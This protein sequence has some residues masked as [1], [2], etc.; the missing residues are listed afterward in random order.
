MIMTLMMTLS[1]HLVYTPGKSG[2]A[3]STPKLVTA[4]TAQT[5]PSL[6]DSIAPPESPLQVSRVPSPAHTW[7]D[8][9][10]IFTMTIMIMS[11]PWCP[12]WSRG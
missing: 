10:M 1:T 2:L 6:E 9:M 4:T 3:Q 7:R 12:R 5:P 11:P 8:V